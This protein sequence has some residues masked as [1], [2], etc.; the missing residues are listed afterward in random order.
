MA[1]LAG[2]WTCDSQV[3]GLSPGWAPICSGLVETVHLYA[4]VTKQYNLVSSKGA[5]SLTGKVTASLVD[6]NSNLPPGLWLTHLPADC[7]ETGRD[8]LDKQ[9]RV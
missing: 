2:Q 4:S 6:S 3:A 1:L 9:S 8:R 7:Q 5:T